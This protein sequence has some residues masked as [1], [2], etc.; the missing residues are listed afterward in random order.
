M[1]PTIISITMTSLPMPM[2]QA[3]GLVKTS[4]KY[5]VILASQIMTR[6]ITSLTAAFN[7]ELFEMR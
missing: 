1:V 4:D 7:E 5:H 6:A 2:S 3:Q